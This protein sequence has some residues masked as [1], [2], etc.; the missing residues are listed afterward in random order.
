LTNIAEYYDIHKAA[1]HFL[2]T[3]KKWSVIRKTSL[4][5]VEREALPRV[6]DPLVMKRMALGLR[7]QLSRLHA[8][9]WVIATPSAAQER[10]L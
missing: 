2:L 3:I 8:G 6:E 10:S 7:A 9:I 4:P 1:G 5:R